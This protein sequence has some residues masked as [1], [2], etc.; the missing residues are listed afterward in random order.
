MKMEQRR[1][2][3]LDLGF[4][5]N[6]GA[7]AGTMRHHT[8]VLGGLLAMELDKWI[9]LLSTRHLLLLP[10]V[11]LGQCSRPSWTWSFQAAVAL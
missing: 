11:N 8:G 5:I 1:A 2:S 7:V 3:K 9:L 10:K 6:G 4:S